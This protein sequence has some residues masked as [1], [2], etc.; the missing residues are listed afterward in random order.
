[1]G[2]SSCL[3]SSFFP[4][5]PRVPVRPGP[6]RACSPAGDAG[7]GGE[8]GPPPPPSLRGAARSPGRC[9][10][11]NQGRVLARA[12][13]GRE[14]GRA[15][16]RR[17][18]ASPA[19]L[20]VGPFGALWVR[21]GSAS[22]L[23]SLP[24]VLRRQGWRIPIAL[25]PRVASACLSG[26]KGGGG[27]EFAAGFCVPEATCLSLP[28]GALL[29][30]F[31]PRGRGTLRVRTGWDPGYEICHHYAIDWSQSATSASPPVYNS[32]A[33]GI[34]PS[35]DAPILARET[36]RRSGS[37]ASHAR[38]STSLQLRHWPSGSSP[39]P[40]TMCQKATALRH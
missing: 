8:K 20:R 4:L 22:S 6:P 17:A 28:R 26:E 36:S 25:S 21:A 19:Q 38:R 10:R 18:M 24:S 29:S 31:L 1:M 33:A 2:V 12:S 34:R 40:K 7:P 9:A 23:P 14:A 27:G 16:S 3:A 32:S 37:T 35:L 30:G 15:P 13:V 11:G 39:K 5:V